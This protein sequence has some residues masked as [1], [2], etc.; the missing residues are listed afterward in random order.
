M[1]QFSIGFG[2]E[3]DDNCLIEVI[4]CILLN[5]SQLASNVI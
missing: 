5:L 1:S 3:Y 4:Q 2:N